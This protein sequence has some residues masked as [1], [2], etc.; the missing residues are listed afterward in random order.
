MLM[1]FSS[2]FSLLPI[3]I[4]VSFVII[5]KEILSSMYV[6][7]ISLYILFVSASLIWV[8][9]FLQCFS[10]V[11]FIISSRVLSFF[12]QDRTCAKSSAS[13]SYLWH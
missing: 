2:F 13:F 9:S 10:H 11:S 8:F 12:S 4:S 6:F 1:C 5:P 3:C 7:L